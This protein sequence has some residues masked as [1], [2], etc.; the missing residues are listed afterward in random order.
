MPGADDLMMRTY[1]AMAQKERELISART[2]AALAAA[3]ARGGAAGRGSGVS[4]DGGPEGGICGRSAPLRRQDRSWPP[5]SRRLGLTFGAKSVRF[6]FGTPR[7]LMRVGSLWSMDYLISKK[8][9][10]LRYSYAL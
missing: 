10:S 2:K 8:V 3:K 4:A 5:A 1:A 6:A 7:T 9:L